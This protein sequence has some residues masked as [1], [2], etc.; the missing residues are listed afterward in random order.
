MMDWLSDALKSG[1]SALSNQVSKFKNREFLD[2]VTSGCAMVAAADGEI[3]SEEKKKMIKFIGLSEEL[4][5]FD[6]NEA[7]T[8]FTRAADLLEFDFDV[9]CDAALKVI[10][11]LRGK[12]DAAK[13]LVRLCCVIGA[14]DGNFDDGEKKIVSRICR[15]VGLDPADFALP[16]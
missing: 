3:S 13:I 4:K 16:V 15:E 7:V 5:I 9:G 11:K 1:R 8:G 10:S 2:A 12:P 14:S 6:S